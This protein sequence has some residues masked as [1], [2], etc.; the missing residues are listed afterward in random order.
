[1]SQEK[2]DWAR[3]GREWWK[4]EGRGLGL[5]GRVERSEFV[6]E[7]EGSVG[8]SCVWGWGRV[9]GSFEGVAETVIVGFVPPSICEDSVDSVGAASCSGVATLAVSA[10]SDG[11]AVSEKRGMEE[12]SK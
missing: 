7:A 9:A 4:G 10:L 12:S 2:E 11:L 5:G 1:M 3:E 8:M 6:E